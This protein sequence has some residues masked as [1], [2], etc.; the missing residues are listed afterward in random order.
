MRLVITAIVVMFIAGM[1]AWL[2]LYRNYCRMLFDIRHTRFKTPLIKSI[3]K[4][5]S[6]CKKLDIRI[7]NVK[8]F[9]E[10]NIDEYRIWGISYAG[11]GKIGRAT[12]YFIAMTAISAAFFM[13][14]SSE[15]VYACLTLGAVSAMALHLFG[16]LTDAPQLYAALVTEL[17]DYMENSGDILHTNLGN[18]GFKKLT[19]RAYID[20]IKLSRC[21]KRI[22]SAS[23]NARTVG[24]DMKNDRKRCG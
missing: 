5:Y 21:Y 17:V 20:F 3:V 10:K 13:R 22:Q 18:G 14:E 7:R 11:F 4:K 8:A 6:D 2:I 9:V 1:A 16:K 12:E 23:Q 24:T 15:A 19:G